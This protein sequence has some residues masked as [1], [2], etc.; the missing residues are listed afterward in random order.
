MD[1]ELARTKMLGQ[2]LRAWEVLD[3]A[4][5]DVFASVPRE[6]F[7]PE[8]FRRLAFADAC[9]P[10]GHGEV[11]MAPPVE[12]RMLQALTLR[13]TDQVLEV[14]T[15]SGF[16]TACLARLAQSVQSIEIHPALADQARARLAAQAVGNAQV[17]VGDA[18]SLAPD[19]PRFDA[20]CVTGSMPLLDPSFQ[21]QL[22]QGGRL[23]AVVGEAPTM[24]AVL[25][26]RV[27]ESVFA[28]ETLFETV[29]PPL[30]N[31]RQAQRF[32]L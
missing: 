21:A 19:M 20:I 1:V 23:F 11:M 5:L 12:G 27:G 6:R 3:G 31:A 15:G 30:R 7:V 4:V 8:R 18:S 10:L 22:K 24:Q 29:L 2:Q 9:I 16:I 26:T 32:V 13:S 25:V 17:E 14:G 28:T